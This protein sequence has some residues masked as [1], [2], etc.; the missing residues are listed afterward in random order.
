M[1]NLKLH[2]PPCDRSPKGVKRE[3]SCL[4]RKSQTKVWLSPDPSHS[5]EPGQSL[6]ISIP[7]QFGTGRSHSSQGA[8]VNPRG[9]S[10]LWVLCLD[11][12]LSS[13]PSCPPTPAGRKAIT[14]HCPESPGTLKGRAGHVRRGTSQSRAATCHLQLHQTAT[15]LPNLGHQPHIQERGAALP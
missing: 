10:Q 6:A 5:L 2:R 7:M 3:L 14:T 15:Q 13:A 4:A 8:T 11:T 9:C 1:L 12:P